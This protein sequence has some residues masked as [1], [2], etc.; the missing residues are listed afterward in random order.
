VPF[1]IPYLKADKNKVSK[2]EG[3]LGEKTKLRVGVVWS[4]MSNFK[5]DDLRSMAFDQFQLA[6]P[7]SVF[8]LICLQKEI[9]PADKEAVTQRADLLLIGDDLHDFDETA[10]VIESL[11]LV[12]STCTSVP[13]LSAAMG[14]PTWVLL[15]HTPDWRWLLHRE[16]SPWY[17][18][19]KLYRQDA[20][21]D[22][23][24]VLARVRADLL[25]ML[26]RASNGW[27]NVAT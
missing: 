25:R 15:A 12:V 18:S 7:V 10:A 13:H 6:F 20:D 26:G 9:K 19:V 21:W 2:W 14:V 27:G 8:D 24:P 23:A 11:D 1:S 16:D 4:S 17:G 3:R 22:W 5:G